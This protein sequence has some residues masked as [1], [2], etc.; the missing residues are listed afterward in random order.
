MSRA[1]ASAEPVR[2]RDATN[3]SWLSLSAS[4][5]CAR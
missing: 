5:G 2:S 3:D 4:V 1:D